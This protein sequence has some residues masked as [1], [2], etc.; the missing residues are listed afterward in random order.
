MTPHDRHLDQELPATGSEADDVFR[1]RSPARHPARTAAILAVIGLGG[2]IGSSAR[3]LL[4][5]ALP[6]PAGG[7][8]WATFLTNVSG[9]FLLGALMVFVLDV[10]PPSRYV[11]PFFGVGVLGGFTTFSTF[12]GEIVHLARDGH[13]AVADSYA[14]DSLIA[15]LV[16][17]WCGMALARTVAGLPSR[18]ARESKERP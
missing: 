18:R 9:C 17:V 12:T 4:A 5:Q 11:R 6:T 15:G 7:F 16:A 8:P 13:W 10:W 2:G 1:A 3:H 14:L